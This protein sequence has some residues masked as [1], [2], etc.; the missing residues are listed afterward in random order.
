MA[1]AFNK[2]EKEN[3]KSRLVEAG[4]DYF[5]YYG[6][7]KTSIRD[8]TRKAGISQGA[9]Y[10]FFDSKEDLYVTIFEEEE[11]RLQEKLY[12]EFI[13]LRTI[14]KDVIKDLLRQ[15]IEY[16]DKNP[17]IK[18]YY[19][20]Y[21]TIIC[22]MADNKIKSKI[23]GDIDVIIPIIEGW[24]RKGYII[25]AKPKVIVG[26]IKSLLYI[27]YHKKEIDEDLYDDV[28]ELLTDIVSTSLI[29]KDKAN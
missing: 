2:I 1:R 3:I 4:K 16:I 22:K 11:R 10:I 28:I 26:L 8:L 29:I 18:Q 17:I 20:S 9:F 6:L 15:T 25:D 13:N 19:S 14:S 21:E 12:N 24:Q 23:E 7:K 5:G 27:S